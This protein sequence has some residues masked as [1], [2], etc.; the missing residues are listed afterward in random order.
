MSKSKDAVR[1]MF[2]NYRE[3]FELLGFTVAELCIISASEPGYRITGHGYT[4]YVHDLG[5]LQSFYF[6]YTTSLQVA[7]RGEKEKCLK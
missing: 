4:F 5:G 6:G 2:L 3:R 7:E 1:D